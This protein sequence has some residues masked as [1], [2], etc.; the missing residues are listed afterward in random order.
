[1]HEVGHHLFYQNFDV[2]NSMAKAARARGWGIP[3]SDY[4]TKNHRELFAEAFSLYM[5]GNKADQA[6]INPK[7]LEWLRHH[8]MGE[9]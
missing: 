8:D 7:I 1:M 3:L 5:A 9:P 4:A 2:L 6:R